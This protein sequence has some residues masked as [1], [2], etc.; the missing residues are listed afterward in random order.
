MGIATV[1]AWFLERTNIPLRRTMFILILAPMGVP[2]IISSMAWI[3]LASPTNGLFN[4]V[5]RELLGL[6]G[7]PGPMNIYTIPGMIVVSALN[8]VTSTDRV[9][10]PLVIELGGAGEGASHDS[11]SPTRRSGPGRSWPALV[12]ARTLPR[13]RNRSP[14]PRRV[15]AAGISAAM[16]SVMRMSEPRSS[17]FV[18]TFVDVTGIIIYFST[19]NIFHRIT[20]ASYTA[21]VPFQTAAVM[22]WLLGYPFRFGLVTPT[23]V[24]QLLLVAWLIAKGFEERRDALVRATVPELA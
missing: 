24:M 1:F 14:A 10:T 11:G 22:L 13:S 9:A 18:A 15:R 20:G 7:G 3:L 23:G 5:L 2:T 4:V 8:F 17:P 21:T 12:Q 19:R 6:G 16:T